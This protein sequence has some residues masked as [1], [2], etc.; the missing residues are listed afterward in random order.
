MH[1]VQQRSDRAAGGLM[2]NSRERSSRYSWA[3]LTGLQ[4]GGALTLVVVIAFVWIGNGHRRDRARAAEC[5]QQ[6]LTAVLSFESKHGRIARYLTEVDVPQCQ[7]K[8]DQRLR[9]EKLEEGWLLIVLER[10]ASREEL[11]ERLCAGMMSVLSSPD[12]GTGVCMRP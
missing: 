2:G 7:L 10:D 9:Y 6:T 12:L 4:F 1:I 3:I 11:I 8:D 5:L